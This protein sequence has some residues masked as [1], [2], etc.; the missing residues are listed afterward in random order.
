MKIKNVTENSLEITL[1]EIQQ[2]GGDISDNQRADIFFKNILKVEPSLFYYPQKI[3]GLQTFLTMLQAEKLGE[4]E[5]YKCYSFPDMM[6]DVRVGHLKEMVNIDPDPYFHVGSEIVAGCMYRKDWTK[7]F[8]DKEIIETATYFRDKPLRYT[9]YA[10]MK[11]KELVDLL[12]ELYPILYDKHENEPAEERE[13]DGRRMYDMVISLAKD[14][15]TKIEQV[16]NMR[17]SRA[18]PYMEEKKIQFIKKQMNQR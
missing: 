10:M 12:K 5:N 11:F 4:P 3:A 1:A 13:D 14:D 9:I 8:D 2:M 6:L 7:G 16:E 15:P 18:F 17:L